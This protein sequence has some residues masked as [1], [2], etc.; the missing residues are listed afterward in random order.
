M[1]LNNQASATGKLWIIGIMALGLFLAAPTQLLVAGE[2]YLPANG[3]Q[4]ELQT[5]G[6]NGEL[7]NGDWW[8]NSMGGNQP[9]LFYLYVP[10][11]VPPD[12]LIRLE[13]YDPECF[14]T[15]TELDEQ[16]NHVWDSTNFRLVAPDNS[17]VVAEHTY[18][19]IDNTSESWNVFAEFLAGAH[20]PGI[21]KLY[22]TTAVDDENSYR[23]RLDEADPDGIPQSG[24]ELNLA[25]MR[26]SLQ[27][28]VNDCVSL[29]YYI[30]Q[31]T[32]L[33]IC[34]F[35]MDNEG[36]ITHY[37]PDNTV[38]PG[39]VS[40]DAMWNLSESA[41]FPPPGGDEI[42]SPQTGWWH[43]EICLITG[44]QLTFTPS[45]PFFF[46]SAP[47]HPNLQ[48]TIDDGVTQTAKTQH[49]DYTVTVTNSDSGAA[50]SITLTVTLSGGLQYINSTG[51][52]SFTAPDLVTWQI[53]VMKP[54]DV[55]TFHV[56]ALVTDF[57][58]APV[59]TTAQAAYE[60]LLFQGYSSS[61]AI[62]SDQL[63]VQG[64]ISGLVFEDI[65]ENG[66]VDPTETG[67]A[68][69]TLYLVR[70]AGE[71]LFTVQ[72]DP[73]GAYLFSAIP[74]GIYYIRVDGS[75]LPPNYG[76]VG[77]DPDATYEISETAEDYEDVNLGFTNLLIPVE[78]SR[79]GA[80]V[81]SGMVILE[82]TTQSESENI[83]F[84]IYRSD[85]AQGNYQRLNRA[86]IQG[87]GSSSVVRHYRYEDS[88]GIAAG[89]SYYY[90]LGDVSY[91]GVE[92]LHGPILMEV[93]AVP[94][95][96]V[97]DQNYPNPFNAETV[98]PVQLAGAGHVKLAIYNLLG[99]EIR[100]LADEPMEAGHHLI[101]W[102][103]MD[104]L[105]QPVP[106]GVYF[107]NLL[108]NDFRGTRK[109]QIIK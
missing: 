36:S 75:T 9:H 16:K 66:T 19:P 40:G 100:H 32:D 87:A 15:G 49:L 73:T 25:A 108:V 104:N 44:N 20:G 65:N 48:V 83:G 78:L 10:P 105:G 71:T 18:P 86:I 101:H 56:G 6:P 47:L 24:D 93:P 59:A 60:D 82:W 17:T 67:L 80:H 51:G 38:V 28:H 55:L 77:H 4:T 84:N 43:S 107:Y 37:Q 57:T 2:L 41:A 102:D 53:D 39:T 7:D 76:P 35:D 61:Q 58:S 90:K 85:A 46:G 92:T 42:L 98:I 3:S 8:A 1:N 99:Q 11:M 12:F 79:F 54:G 23:L 21:Y 94:Q 52:G 91:K 106:A 29:Y 45:T 33:R 26:T 88:S 31:E 64:S 69:V 27:S 22:V 103:G 5:N 68:D 14:A 109:M 95:A 81:E 89:R 63:V 30:P 62:D 97:L 74:L 72:S 70:T 13:I 34:N 50:Q 96:Y